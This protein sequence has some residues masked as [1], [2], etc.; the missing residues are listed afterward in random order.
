MLCYR[1]VFVWLGIY[2]NNECEGMM[3][4]RPLKA[5]CWIVIIFYMDHLALTS[6]G[7]YNI[8]MINIEL[9]FQV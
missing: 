7:F 1:I 5:I 3:I 2:L 4:G 9:L 6:I 8:K